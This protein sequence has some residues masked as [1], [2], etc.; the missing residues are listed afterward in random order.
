M[1][2]RIALLVRRLA[3]VDLRRNDRV[4]G[5]EVIVAQELVERDDIVGEPLAAGRKHARH[6]GI[7]A[8]ETGHMVGRSP[9]QAEGRLRPGLGKQPARAQVG[10]AV[11][12]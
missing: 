10:V 8:E 4:A 11:G 1:E 7:P 6:R 3:A 2:R 12:I 5:V 9:H